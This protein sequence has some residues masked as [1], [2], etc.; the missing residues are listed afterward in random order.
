[1]DT[2][3][4]DMLLKTEFFQEML[5]QLRALDTYGTQEKRSPLELLAPFLLSPERK[6]EIAIIANLDEKTLSRIRTYYNALSASIE[7]E[8][9]LMAVPLINL[10]H[11]GFGRVLILVGKLVVVDKTLRDAHRFGF[12]SLEKMSTESEKLV[13]Q[14]LTLIQNYPEVAKL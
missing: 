11:E 4:E 6:K 9:Q 3:T 5:K 13:K 7:K 12:K 1:M 2:V 10:S 8:S 14:A